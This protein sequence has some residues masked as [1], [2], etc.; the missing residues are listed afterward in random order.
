VRAVV[1]RV[2]KATVS[3]KGKTI[4]EIGPGLL[5]LL[6]IS[7]E[8]TEKDLQYIVDKVV[9]LRIFERNGKFDLSV[10]E[11]SGE[12]LLVSQFTLYGDCRK[13]R[14]P[15]F[16]EAAPPNEARHLYQLALEKFA[17]QVPT[18]S[19]WFQERMIVTLA[20]NGPV[21]LLI[22]SHKKF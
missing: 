17:A 5:I 1:Q 9:N 16:T 11:V 15:S 12:I 20:N 10:K 22:D 13:G 18:K 4:A 19:G 7:R 21:T 8:D 6:G 2:D 14:R 3:V